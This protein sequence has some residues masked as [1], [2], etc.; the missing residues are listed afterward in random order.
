MSENSPNAS[1]STIR[2]ASARLAPAQQV[3]VEAKLLEDLQRVISTQQRQIEDQLRLL[4]WMYP[5]RP[6]I[7]FSPCPSTNQPFPIAMWRL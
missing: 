7:A 5:K 4:R 3:T 2:S 6:A 1:W